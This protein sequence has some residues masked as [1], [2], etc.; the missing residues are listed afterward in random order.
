MKND[1]NL[2]AFAEQGASAQVAI[3]VAN[4]SADPR[5]DLGLSAGPVGTAGT[6]GKSLEGLAKLK[7]YQIF[8]SLT[9]EQRIGNNE[10]LGQ[11]KDARAQYQRVLV[12][13][14]TLRA[15]VATAAATSVQSAH[16]AM[17]RMEL[18]K[19]AIGLSEK[20]IEAER[21]RFESGKSTNFDVLQR[22]DEQK[23]A[24]LRYARAAI[25]YL[26]ATIQIHALSGELLDRYGVTL[27]Q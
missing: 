7:G 22:Q 27:K 19:I 17:K 9:Y 20:N 15:Q 11:V 1:P 4:N 23:Q 18:S 25:D 14:R 8:S 13:E 5:L 10:G 16:I 24:R 26:R 12:N 21:R 6:L 2:A 3:R